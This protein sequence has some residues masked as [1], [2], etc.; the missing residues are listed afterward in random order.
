VSTMSRRL[1]RRLLPLVATLAALSLGAVACS[2][3]GGGGG[4]GPQLSHAQYQ[5][6]LTQIS[7]TFAKEQKTAFT[8]IDITNPGDVKKL[9]DRFRSAADAIDGVADALNGL[10]APNDAAAAYGKLVDGFH[11]IA[12]ALRQLATAAD[13]GDLQKLQ[14]LST[15]FSKGAAERELEQAASELEK[16]GYKAPTPSG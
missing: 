14:S 13:Q 6:K 3:G 8:G 1:V 4:G 11:K 9:G 15:E 10:N 16:A 2:S 12:D 7:Q 5:Q